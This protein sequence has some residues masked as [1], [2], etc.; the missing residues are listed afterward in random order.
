LQR[1][2]ARAFAAEGPELSTSQIYD[3]CFTKRRRLTTLKGYMVW[4]V[5]VKVADPIRKT[6]P[7]NA[8]LW[9]LRDTGEN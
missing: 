3:W 2:I 7:H 8:W 6:P 9:R 4:R 5:L 1:Q